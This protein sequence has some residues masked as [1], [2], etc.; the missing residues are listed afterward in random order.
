MR[1]CHHLKYQFN[2]P[3]YYEAEMCLAPPLIYNG[4]LILIFEGRE[5]Y[6]GLKYK[7]CLTVASHILHCRYYNHFE[8]EF[9]AS[10]IKDCMLLSEYEKAYN[11]FF[12][13]G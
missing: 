3:H 2:I 9:A 8:K 7:G 6:C 12:F 10:L 11:Y 1:L 4:L 5:V 13:G